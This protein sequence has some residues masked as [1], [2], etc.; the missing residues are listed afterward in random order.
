M[1]TVYWTVAQLMLVGEGLA[2]GIGIG[3]GGLEDREQSNRIGTVLFQQILGAPRH[4]GPGSHHLVDGMHFTA[5][6]PQ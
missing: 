1:R 5:R 2:L 4:A 6:L 3:Q